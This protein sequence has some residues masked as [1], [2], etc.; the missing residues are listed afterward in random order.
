VKPTSGFT[1]VI[2]A[3]AI[4]GVCG[5][6]ITWWVARQIGLSAYAIFAVFWALIYLIIGSLSGI[7]QEIA[8]A[9]HPVSA[10]SE[11]NSRG[12]IFGVSTSVIVAAVI[13]GTAPAWVNFAF[14]VLGWAL[15]WPLAVGAASFVLVAVVSGTFYGI[16]AWRVLS[17]IIVLDPALRLAGLVGGLL[18]T[19]DVVVLAWLV[20]L[21]I[22]AT[23]LILS[24][25]LR[26]TLRGRTRIDVGYQRL[27]W[28]SGRVVVAA[29]A[30]SLMVSGFPFVIGV[31][32]HGEDA[33]KVGLLILSITLSRAP[34]V[35]TAM[36]LQSFLVVHFRDLR[37]SIGKSFLR[38]QGIVL[39][40][41]IAIGSGAW[42][43]GPWIFVLLFPKNPAPEAWLL[44]VL[45]LSSALVASMC[46]SAAALLA[47]SQH[48]AFSL[49]WVTAAVV[50]VGCELAPTDLVSRTLLALL[51]GP[52][53][54]LIVH[55]SFLASRVV[56]PSTAAK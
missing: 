22:P 15:V 11:A 9:S 18:F 40:A 30:L 53:V 8:R 45:V 36:A 2:V 38:I 10:R 25:W 52:M 37:T 39:A 35:V 21:P 33:S 55:V 32:S 49:G 56:Q 27:I 12:L 54:G 43:L 29:A 44:A 6:L 16:G 34:L 26:S 3:T 28:N 46:I 20:A 4:A 13:L 42:L 51:V 17:G 1:R 5:Y 7:Q 47:R 31:T 41:T 24:P 14:P 50:T 19:R 48:L 23:V